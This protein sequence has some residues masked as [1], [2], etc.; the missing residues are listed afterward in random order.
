MYIFVSNAISQKIH[1]SFY[2]E[3]ARAQI[4]DV[5]EKRNPQEDKHR[6]S[7]FFIVAGS[8]EA[9]PQMPDIDPLYFKNE[10]T[11]DQFD[12]V[13]GILVKHIPEV[14]LPYVLTKAEN[15]ASEIRQV[16]SVLINVPLDLG[17]L[18][19][20]AEILRLQSV[21][22]KV[23]SLSKLYS[24][25]I[26]RVYIDKTGFNVF[27]I[28][29][30]YPQGDDQSSVRAV[31]SASLLLRSLDTVDIPIYI[32]ISTGQAVVSVCGHYRK[33]L[34][35]IGEPLYMSY[36]LSLIALKDGTKRILVDH[37]TKLHTEWKVSLKSYS[38]PMFTEKIAQ[39]VF[40]PVYN[41]RDLEGIP[42]NAFPEIRTHRFNVDYTK[43]ITKQDYEDSI[44]MVGREDKV[45]KGRQL[46]L[47]FVKTPIK[48]NILFVTGC[49]GV[50]KSLFLRNL[51]ENVEEMLKE[52]FTRS[53]R[54]DILISSIDPIK[55][56][57][58]LNGWRVIFKEISGRLCR[59]LGIN[60][61]EL[62][63]FLFGAKQYGQRSKQLIMNVFGI[64]K[65]FEERERGRRNKDFRD[66][67]E[68]E[69]DE[70]D[71]REIVE[72]LTA[73]MQFYVGEKRLLVKGIDKQVG[74]EDMDRFPP[75]IICFDDLQ[76]HDL[77]SWKVF[78]KIAERLHRVF[79]IGALREEDK[80]NSPLFM[81]TKKETNIF[82]S[83]I[84]SVQ[85]GN[86]YVDLITMTEESYTG[87]SSKGQ[88]KESID[89]IRRI[90]PQLINRSNIQFTSFQLTELSEKEIEQLVGR[91]LEGKYTSNELIRLVI[92]RSGKNPLIA[93]DLLG[94]FLKQELLQN[95]NGEWFPSEILRNLTKIGQYIEVLAPS[96]IYKKGIDM[97]D[98]LTFTCTNLLKIASIVGNTFDMKTLVSGNSLYHTLLPH[99]TLVLAI[100]MLVDQRII[101]IV[102]DSSIN[103]VY[104]FCSAFLR[105]TIYQLIPY[106]QRKT[107]HLIIATSM[108]GD[109][110]L[111]Q[112]E[113]I[114]Y[115]WA[116]AD[117]ESES[118]DSSN[119]RAKREIVVNQL[120]MGET[121]QNK[122]GNQV[123]KS[124]Q[125]RKKSDKS[126]KVTS[127]FVVITKTALKY[128]KT[129]ADFR[130][131]PVFETGS[132][133]LKNIISVVIFSF[134]LD[135]SNC[136]SNKSQAPKAH[137]QD[138]N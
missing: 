94:A 132:I 35:I 47:Q 61:E 107:Q 45:Y 86:A 117:T 49:Y 77:L 79:I 15:W 99:K 52:K 76:Y 92:Q 87:R 16:T 126:D 125:L 95:I 28:F 93:V 6:F 75:V 100:Q 96:S 13:K 64:K 2:L 120:S 108:L 31:L 133:L 37:E 55:Q 131:K 112:T 71:E 74:N 104:K 82:L 83:N 56:K 33:D 97:L 113:Q 138:L 78:A 66:L 60:K 115:H 67:N 84:Q 10:I 1:Q 89:V 122:R 17:H 19:F 81:G 135:Y 7:R 11:E 30:L 110:D 34:F 42:G 44:Y 14:I 129:E 50:G 29:G 102:D 5:S 22:Q 116:L 40:E 41:G 21:I 58:K 119:N 12:K 85:H 73:V 39:G 63:D 128:Y 137:L 53:E 114:D 90:V 106:S 9:L 134:F 91:V 4:T 127:R 118:Q 26:Y 70:E 98:S 109:S 103:I 80:E 23:Q 101:Q 105:E 65:E 3:E 18:S 57:Q 51:L 136:F 24:A 69:M 46:I 59:S 72:I 38:N 130:E 111:I 124:D 121:Q 88:V 54:P 32:G 25:T 123:F 48:M 36:L 68:T 8:K 27:M 43:N 20:E 62:I